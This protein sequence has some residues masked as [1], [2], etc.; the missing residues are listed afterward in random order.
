VSSAGEPSPGE[1]SPPRGPA[2]TAVEQTLLERDGE[3]AEL[4]EALSEAG[5][6]RGCVVLIEAPAGIGK[7]SLLRAA[8]EAA[9]ASGFDV[10]R[11]RAT[12]LERDFAYGSVRQLLEPAIARA[13]D[14]ER[15][16]LFAGAA[17]LSKPLF[18][19]TGA[20][21]HA[22]SPDSAFAILHGLYW[23]VDNIAAGGPVV[24]AVADVHWA[25]P[26]SV[27]FFN[28]LAPRLD[29]LP[30]ALLATTRSGE[31][32]AADLARLAAAPETTELRPRALTAEA[33]LGLCELRLGAEVA[34]EF[35]AACRDVTGGNPFFLEALLREVRERGL[36]PDAI[37]AE[38]ARG[39]GPAAVAESV[40]LR[41]AAAPAAAALVRAVAVI[42]DGASLA[43]ATRLAGLDPEEAVVAA[44]TLAALALLAAG[45]T[46]EFAHPIVREA[47]WADIGAHERAKAHARAAAILAAEGASEERIAAQLAHAEPA[48]D[49]E[50]VS[51][52]RRVAAGALSRGAPAAAAAWLRRALAEPPPPSERGE[53]LLELSSAELRLGAPYAAVDQLATAAKLVETPEQV[54]TAVRLLAGALTWSGHADR[55]VAAIG[56]AIDS[57]EG[58]DR[59]LALLLEAERAAYAQQGSLE[60]RAPVAAR[61][62]RFAGLPGATPGERLVLASLAFE[63]ARASESAGE[64]AAYVEQAL[65]GR[66]LLDEQELDVAGTLYLLVLCLLGTD[67]LDL[68]DATLKAMLADARAR[69]SIPA[70]AFVIVHRGWVSLRRG[71]VAQAEDDARRA[72]DLLTTYDIRLGTRF[73]L[74][75]LIHALIE[76]GEVDAAWE[77]LRGSGED[78]EIPAGMASNALLEARGVLRV[79]SGDPAAGLDDLEAFGRNDELFGAV[80]P[81]A[82]RWR[83][84]AALALSELGEAGRAG[85]VAEDEL[86]RARRWGAAGGIGVALRAS[87]LVEGGDECVDRLR[88][89]VDALEGSPARLE[90]AR[91]LTDLGAALRRGNRRSEARSVLASALELAQ[92]CRAGALADRARTELRV[93]GGR[94]S[95]RQG[96]GLEQLTVSERRVAEL[97][98]EGHSNPEIAQALFVTRK[99]V[100]THLGRVYRKLGVSG[101]VRLARALADEAPAAEL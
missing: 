32:D 10:L 86:G 49:P 7:T 73:A 11:A 89:A 30:L 88:E 44:D 92:L 82:S 43:E 97:A 54:A 17:A 87:A 95:D 35:A 41:L 13:S 83:S 25:D 31:S 75:L 81:L 62:E 100:E 94:V 47:V 84:R 9:S 70:E 24:L 6:G 29:G 20:L 42:G 53:V 51:L 34:P 4:R 96:S 61:L 8:C 40:L 52:L 58:K 37:G 93:A 27:R 91:A 38:R 77:A 90:H 45:E 3:L 99:T 71:A 55:A 85:E 48:G 18:T 67:A 19:P 22:S 5:E 16:R 28:F 1:P 23:L 65:A 57:L 78:E 39:I 76:D 98:A 63:R 79:A 80:N 101:R 66:S 2:A 64:A 21:Q 46:L 68:A 36:A 33:T 15:D 12:E 60:T 59:E 69:A 14:E 72:L 26:E 56:S 50:R 74:A